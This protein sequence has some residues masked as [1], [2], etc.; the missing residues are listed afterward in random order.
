MVFRIIRAYGMALGAD[1]T[2]LSYLRDYKRWDNLA[3]AVLLGVI[4]CFGDAL[5]VS[6]AS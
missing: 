4:V 6:L 2:P 1:G 5:V 3:H